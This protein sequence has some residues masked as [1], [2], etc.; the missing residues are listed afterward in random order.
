MSDT[1]TEPDTAALARRFFELARLPIRPGFET[2]VEIVPSWVVIGSVVEEMERRGYAADYHSHY[3]HPFK[4]WS[5]RFTFG[6]DDG[7]FCA[8]LL[9]AVLMAANAALES[10]VKA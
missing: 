6:D 1:K 4:R 5:Y 2:W 10:E 7:P 9:D 3:S 8:S